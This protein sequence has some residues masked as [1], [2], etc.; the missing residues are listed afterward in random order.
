MT[1]CE[2]AS[3]SQGDLSYLQKS[4]L[5]SLTSLLHLL[6]PQPQAQITCE[7]TAQVGAEAVL[8]ETPQR[9]DVSVWGRPVCQKILH[10]VMDGIWA[11]ERPIGGTKFHLT[12]CQETIKGNSR[13]QNGI[14]KGKQKAAATAVAVFALT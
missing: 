7:E 12:L 11:G 10:D 4:S 3:A 13:N 6:P 9:Q 8:Q 2:S 1:D 5:V 14:R